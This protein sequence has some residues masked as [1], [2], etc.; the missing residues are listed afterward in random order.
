MN[1]VLDVVELFGGPGGWSEGLRNARRDLRSIGIEWDDRAAAT[2]IAAGHDRLVADV[3]LVDPL[4]YRD[5]GVTGLI[6][7]PPCQGFSTAGKGHG[8]K[9]ADL[10]I[11]TILGCESMTDV[12]DAIKHLAEHM[13]DPRSILVLEPLRWAL[14]IGPEWMAWEQV[15]TVR[16]VW[17]ACAKVLASKGY[18]VEVAVLNAEQYG[19]PQTRRRAILVARRNDE[20]ELPLPTHSKY[21]SR[22]PLKLD[23]G[24]LPWVSMSDALGWAVYSASGPK[25]ASAT[26]RGRGERALGQPSF[27]ITSKP[28]QLA[29]SVLRNGNQAHSAKRDLVEPAATVHF[30]RRSNKVEFINKTDAQDPKKSGRRITVQEAGVLQSFPADYPWSGSKSS[31]YQQVGDAVPPLLAQRIIEALVREPWGAKGGAK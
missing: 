16:P 12:E 19:V 29:E 11:S 23:E 21:Y 31:Q 28:P 2:A 24:V 4:D 15:A 26:Q 20:A 14:A 25:G 27:A 13:H 30:G 5:L 8:R 7:S 22:N 9:D 3:S 17:D 18:S 6:A 10:L 1:S